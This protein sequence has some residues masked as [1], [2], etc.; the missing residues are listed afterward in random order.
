MIVRKI[1]NGISGKMAFRIF[2]IGFLFCTVSPRIRIVYSRTTLVVWCQLVGSPQR[3]RRWGP[4]QYSRCSGKSWES[5]D[6]SLLSGLCCSRWR[7]RTGSPGS[8]CQAALSEL[9]QQIKNYKCQVVLTSK[10]YQWSNKTCYIRCSWYKCGKIY[11]E[12]RK[13]FGKFVCNI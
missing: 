5:A 2:R 9:L 10:E 6:C 8:P 1:S 4:Y 7:A 3:E 12:L 11:K 13:D